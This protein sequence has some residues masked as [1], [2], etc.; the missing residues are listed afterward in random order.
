M[1]LQI[2][3]ESILHPEYTTID[4]ITN[5]GQG[6]ILQKEMIFL[7]NVHDHGHEIYAKHGDCSLKVSSPYVSKRNGGFL[8]IINHPS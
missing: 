2:N 6:L 5:W 7:Y 8:E 4:L 3:H 1:R